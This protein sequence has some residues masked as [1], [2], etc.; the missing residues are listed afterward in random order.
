METKHAAW[1]ALE[2]LVSRLC[3]ALKAWRLHRGTVRGL[4][5]LPDDLLKDIGVERS[6]IRAVA[7]E[8]TR[9]E[10]TRIAAATPADAPV[11]RKQARRPTL[12]EACCAEPSLCE[13]PC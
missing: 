1:H 3:Q 6:Q 9:R 8:V 12:V 5:R 7:D 13:Q 4:S 2:S 10:M 11:E